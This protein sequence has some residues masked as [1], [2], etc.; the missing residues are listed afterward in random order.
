ME[1][2]WTTNLALDLSRRFLRMIAEGYRVDV[3]DDRYI[4][5]EN[6]DYRPDDGSEPYFVLDTELLD[7][8]EDDDPPND[9]DD[10]AD[11]AAWKAHRG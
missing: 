11:R 8:P 3:F 9:G 2:D 5:V 7:P 10:Y 4:R 1:N 6:P